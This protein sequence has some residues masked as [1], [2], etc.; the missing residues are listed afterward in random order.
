M[1]FEDIKKEMRDKSKKMIGRSCMR[2]QW[3][4]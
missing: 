2:K 4:Y 3:T 1:T